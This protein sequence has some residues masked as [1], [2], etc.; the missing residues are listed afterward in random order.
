MRVMSSFVSQTQFTKQRIL[1]VLLTLALV[2]MAWAGTSP[3]ASSQ[4]I[5]LH[6]AAAPGLRIDFNYNFQNALPPFQK[7]PALPGKEIARGLIP[8]VP[9]TPL[10]RNINDK[11]LLLNTDHTRDFVNG[12]V[13]T[14]HSSYNGHVFFRDLR[15]SSTRDGLEI[16]YTLDLFTYEPVSYTH[17]SLQ[18]AG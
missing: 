4:T 18:L 9:P 5:I 10:L 8:T 16:P 1:E 13:A 3:S 12:K 11:E 15:V 2:Q 14:Y 7:E 6:P 17:L